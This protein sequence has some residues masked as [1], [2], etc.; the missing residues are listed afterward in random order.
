[1]PIDL[2][3]YLTDDDYRRQVIQED[4]RS[5]YA[6]KA[7]TKPD[8]GFQRERDTSEDEEL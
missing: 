7:A 1:M 2:R 4:I 3:R 5:R 6:E 8:E